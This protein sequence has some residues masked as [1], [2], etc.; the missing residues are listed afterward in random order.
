MSET[1]NES[2]RDIRAIGRET[3]ETVLE[4]VRRI[5]EETGRKIRDMRMFLPDGIGFS[6]VFG[7]TPGD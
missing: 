5:E 3:T 4:A 2:T 1:I 7:D 6:V